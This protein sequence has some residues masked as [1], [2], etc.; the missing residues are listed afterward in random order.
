M[1]NLNSIQRLRTTA[2]NSAA[3]AVLVLLP[4]LA[5]GGALVPGI[6]DVER[7]KDTTAEVSERYFAPLHI[8][9]RPLLIPKDFSTGFV[10]GLMDFDQLFAST[11]ASDVLRQQIAR[12]DFGVSGGDL[13]IFDDIEE[14]V[15][16]VLFN[17]AVEEPLFEDDPGF[18]D[19]SL[20]A[21]IPT[22]WGADSPYNFDAFGGNGSQVLPVPEPGTG[23]LLAIG[24]AGIARFGSRAQK[25]A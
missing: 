7:K 17:D 21:L 8:N 1:A 25:N 12:M 15:R 9:R 14:F 18:F 13:I 6:V 22:P 19:D 5:L 16:N 20:F 2:R 11:S 10:P 23:I 3:S 4:L 24:L